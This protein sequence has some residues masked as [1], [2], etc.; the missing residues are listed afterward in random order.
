[1]VTVMR[2]DTGHQVF[3]A[4]LGKNI[5]KAPAESVDIS[6]QSALRFQMK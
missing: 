5:R 4:L 3:H 1:M 6:G 2:V